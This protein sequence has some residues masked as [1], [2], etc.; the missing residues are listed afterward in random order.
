MQKQK[1]TKI[2]TP[3][4]GGYKIQYKIQN[5]LVYVCC[6]HAPIFCVCDAPSYF[7]RWHGPHT[8]ILVPTEAT[9]AA[10][11][12]IL[13]MLSFIIMGILEEDT[14]GGG[15]TTWGNTTRQRFPFSPPR[16]F[17]MDFA[18]A[19]LDPWCGQQYPYTSVHPCA[20]QNTRTQ[21]YIHL[22]CNRLPA[23]TDVKNTHTLIILVRNSSADPQARFLI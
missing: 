2:G 11:A 5:V 12:A 10:A 6:P 20:V 7:C 17:P 1:Q 16:A 3:R 15:E 19:V 4:A 13:D 18:K 23:R 14:D 22:V 21:Q 8:D 9:A